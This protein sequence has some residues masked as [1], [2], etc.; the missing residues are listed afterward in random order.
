MTTIGRCI[1]NKMR[2]WHNGD[3]TMGTAQPAGRI[4]RRRHR[5]V[6]C[7][8]V[9]DDGG[10][11]GAL[12]GR[13]GGELRTLLMVKLGSPV[14]FWRRDV[15]ACMHNIFTKKYGMTTHLNI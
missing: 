13:V 7:I 6:G 1:G 11:G 5:V 14:F 8:S 3:K 2:R 4:R 15:H 9:G 10:Q 12:G